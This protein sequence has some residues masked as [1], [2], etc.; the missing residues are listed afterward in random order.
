M[1]SQH[2]V[3]GTVLTRVEIPLIVALL[4]GLVGTL[5]LG[6]YWI[7]CLQRKHHAARLEQR[8][9]EEAYCAAAFRSRL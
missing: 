1:Q 8:A 7:R 3:F 5:Y 6:I 2:V 9:R 4:A